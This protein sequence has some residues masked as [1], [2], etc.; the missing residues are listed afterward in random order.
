MKKVKNSFFICVLMSCFLV[1]AGDDFTNPCALKTYS[2]ILAGAGFSLSIYEFGK[3]FY[4]NGN[5]NKTPK[6][7]EQADSHLFNGIIFLTAATAFS[8]MEYV[9]PSECKGY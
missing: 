2:S 9:C 4:D 8:V 3:A 5:P 1:K 6:E 7:K